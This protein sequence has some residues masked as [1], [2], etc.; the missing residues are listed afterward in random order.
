MSQ[1]IIDG[2][3][4]NWKIQIMCGRFA[5]NEKPLRFAEHFK[6]KGEIELTPAWNIAPSLKIATITDDAEGERHLNRMRWGLIPGWAK[7]A[8][9]GNKLSNA[10]GETVAEKPSFRA[11]FKYRR[12]LIP[13]SGFYE[14]KTVQEVKHPWYMSYKSGDPMAFAGIWEAWKSAEGETIQTCCIITTSPNTLMEKIHDRMPVILDPDQ[15]DVWLSN[16]EHKVD[17]LL[18]YIRPH[19]ADSM[20]AWPVT[21]ELNRVGLRNDQGLTEPVSISE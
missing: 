16:Q 2:L 10:R 5:L 19:D 1:A 6:L 12:C 18:P 7:D 20:Q 13:A 4:S 14:W 9:I 21:R 8:S 11:A 17:E 3:H 15:W